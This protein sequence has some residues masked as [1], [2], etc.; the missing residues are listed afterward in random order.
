VGGIN[1]MIMT[2]GTDPPVNT[3]WFAQSSALLQAARLRC[4][5]ESASSRLHHR[6]P[7]QGLTTTAEIAEPAENSTLRSLRSP[8]HRALADVIHKR[9]S[10]CREADSPHAPQ[11]GFQ[12]TS[13]QRCRGGV[14][15]EP[16]SSL[17]PQ[18]SPLCV[19]CDLCGDELGAVSSRRDLLRAEKRTHHI[20]TPES[21]SSRL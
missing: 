1:G 14:S 19:L 2:R 21:A 11:V 6:D 8:R 12:P 10:P 13:A 5:P 20:C 16:Q 9:S 18:S 17:S 7:G 4:T 3:D 15:Q